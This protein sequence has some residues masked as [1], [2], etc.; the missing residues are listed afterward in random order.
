ML[1]LLIAVGSLVTEH[2]LYGAWA[3]ENVAHRLSC[4][5][6][7]GIFLD[8]GWHLYPLVGRH[9]LNHWITREVPIF[10]YR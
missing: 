6:A 4:P 8:Q 7:C 5:V 1:G 3:S 2:R 9:I 10:L